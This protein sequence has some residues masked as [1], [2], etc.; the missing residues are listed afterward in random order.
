M[1]MLSSTMTMRHLRVILLQ[2]KRISTLNMLYIV[3]HF[4]HI[5]SNFYT[6]CSDLPQE[7][8]YEEDEGETCTFLSPKAYVG[9]S[10]SNMVHKKKHVMPQRISLAR[11]YEIGTYVPYQPCMESKSRNQPLLSNGKRPTSF[12]AIPPKRTRTAARQQVV[13]PFHAGAS[14]PP[15]DFSSGNTNSYQDDQSSLHSESLPWRNMDFEST[16]DSDRQLPYDAG[17]MCT[18]VNNKKK[19]K[20]SGYKIAQ[21]AANLYVPT[22]AKVHFSSFIGAPLLLLVFLMFP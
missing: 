14:V 2:V 20:N 15:Q 4:I 7:N 11:P 9:G 5:C 16:V 3:M 19:L 6:V 21:N 18:K 22:S 1:A 17:E 8:A 12:L 10:I 13:S